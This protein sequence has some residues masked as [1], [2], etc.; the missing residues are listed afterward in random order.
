MVST[1]SRLRKAITFVRIV[2]HS[3]VAGRA[4][5]AVVD[6]KIGGGTRG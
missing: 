6:T 5:R 1:V 2:R 4:S 3:R